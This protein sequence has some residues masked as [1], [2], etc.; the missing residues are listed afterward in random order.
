[1]IWF[2]PVHFFGN[3]SESGFV[4]LLLGGTEGW[5]KGLHGGRGDLR[6]PITCV[7]IFDWICDGTGFPEFNFV[8]KFNNMI[9]IKNVLNLQA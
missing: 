3:N 8:L 2:H 6:L 7:P 5:G 9:K 4:L 1:V